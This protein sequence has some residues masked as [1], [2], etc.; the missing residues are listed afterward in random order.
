MDVVP[1]LVVVQHYPLA[2]QNS[3]PSSSV[4]A[5]CVGS[6]LRLVGM[7]FIEALRQGRGRRGLEWDKP[8]L[9]RLGELVLVS[10]R[11]GVG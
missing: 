8:I 6:V 7:D 5:R 3:I 4:A 9:E 10:H 11:G 1:F 2:T